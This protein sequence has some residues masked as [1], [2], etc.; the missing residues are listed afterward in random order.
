MSMLQARHVAA[1]AQ[2]E[3]DAPYKPG[4]RIV[5]TSPEGVRFLVRVESVT[6]RATGQFTL[7]GAIVEPR[8]FRGHLLSTVVSRDGTGPA[9]HSAT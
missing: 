8:R 2:A 7:L 4:D 9:I 5:A 1:P 3:A 6:P